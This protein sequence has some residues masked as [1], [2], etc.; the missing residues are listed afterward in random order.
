ME[1]HRCHTAFEKGSLTLGA[2]LLLPRH[3]G[4]SY[5]RLLLSRRLCG[6]PKD[7][8][9]PTTLSMPVVLLQQRPAGLWV[10]G[11][12]KYPVE[13]DDFGG[14]GYQHAHLLSLR[15]LQASL[16]AAFADERYSYTPGQAGVLTDL[17]LAVEC[18]LTSLQSFQSHAWPGLA[19][20][21][22]T[23]AAL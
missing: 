9:N 11:G 8:R 23:C 10:D 20:A 1:H 2:I 6:G 18:R 17:N 14:H 7:H 21:T 12:W 19:L 13:K 16:A 15:L 5:L 3:S 22:L 4:G